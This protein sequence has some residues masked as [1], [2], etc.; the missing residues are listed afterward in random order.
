MRIVKLV[1]TKEN[2][3]VAMKCDK[4]KTEYDVNS[5]IFEV[6]EF[7]EIEQN[8]G[9]GSVFGDGDLIRIDICQHCMKKILIENGL[10][11]EK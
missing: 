4:C 8:C 6:Q 5:D 3:L 9:Y 7:F 2:E 10:L 11:N 1:D